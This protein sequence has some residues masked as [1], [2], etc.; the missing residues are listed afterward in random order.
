MVNLTQKQKHVRHCD[1]TFDACHLPLKSYIFL[2]SRH[3]SLLTL[4]QTQL[5]LHLHL[6]Q[7]DNQSTKKLPPEF[8]HIHA[9]NAPRSPR[10]NLQ[11][12]R[13]RQD[14]QMDERAGREENRRKL[15]R[16]CTSPYLTLPITHFHSES[17]TLLGGKTFAKTKLPSDHR[18]IAPDSMVTADHKPDR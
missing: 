2:R 6:Q 14:E 7:P 11:Q 10:P 13:R 3:L 4:K 16:N 1:A 8:T 5:T 12:R 17:L 18:V 15:Q 9:Q